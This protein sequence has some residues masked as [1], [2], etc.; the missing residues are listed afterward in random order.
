MKNKTKSLL[1]LSS[2]ALVISGMVA[3][4]SQPTAEKTCT[5][6][7]PE[8]ATVYTTAKGDSS[9]RLTQVATLQPS[10]Y[11]QPLETE[12]FIYIDPTHTFQTMIGIGGAITDAVAENFSTLSPEKQQEFLEKYY[13]K[14]KG[15]GYSMIR[16]HI[17]SCDFGYDMYTYIADYD[18]TLATFDM[19]RDTVKRLPLVKK[20]METAG[21]TLPLYLS[22]WSAPAWMKDNNSRIHGGKIKPQY[23]QLWADYVCKYIGAVEAYG[24][25]V[26]GL[27]VQN[28]PMA[29]Q[30][31]ESCIYTAEE[32]R[33]YVKNNLG[34]TLHK[35]GYADKKLF[36]WD[37]NRDLIFHRAS[38]ILNDP[39][40]A[41]YVT[42]VAY[43]WYE[44]WTGAPMNFDALKMTKAT[45]PDKELMFSECCIEGFTWDKAKDWASGEKY[46]YSIMNDL[47]SGTAAW[48]DW[49]ILLNHYGG[50]TW[51]KNFCVSPVHVTEE[52]ELFYTN[53]YYY[54][55]HFSKF[56]RP[57]AKRLA[58]YSSRA[59][60][61]STS[62]VNPDGSVAV[63]V[64]NQG[65]NQIDFNMIMS[66]K[67][68]ACSSLPHS[69]STYILK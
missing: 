7:I 47:N 59:Y 41:K 55:G 30:T 36:I 69:I 9:L 3:C 44:T 20:A 32:E 11:K 12:T 56:I 19:S 49:N 27:T 40:A 68:F 14:E 38:T 26:W 53:I 31:W 17:N 45:F 57:G 18:S 61:L 48:N 42:G 28:E 24:I 51:V 54:I 13:D 39:E 50:P 65:D 52:G 46:G 35:N 1:G 43:H 58:S 67:Q 22:T 34:P 63:V 62:F 23:L 37:H 33:D 5:S 10:E 21:G 66:G 2:I 16:T 15:I 6:L 60:L 25:P 4:S 8:S 64:M 29:S